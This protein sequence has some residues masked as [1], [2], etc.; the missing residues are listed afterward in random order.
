MHLKRKHLRV[1]N[2]HLVE[3]KPSNSFPFQ[4]WP[5]QEEPMPRLHQ[6]VIQGQELHLRGIP[7][8]WPHRPL[9][10]HL[11]R[12][13]CHLTLLSAGM[14]RRDH[15]LH[16]GQALH[17]LKDQFVAFLQRK[18]KFQ[19]QESHL[20]LHSLSHLLQSLRFLMG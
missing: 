16:L 1:P 2:M 14:R 12:V 6:L 18:P 3:H 5:R 4:P 17:V 10:F 7:Y 15:P 9:P 13:E 11:L 20:H 8:Q 19:A